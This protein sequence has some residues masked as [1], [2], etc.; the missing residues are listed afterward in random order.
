ML[1][2]ISRDKNAKG[3]RQL[4]IR[5]QLEYVRHTRGTI[6]FVNS[7]AHACEPPVQ[8]HKHQTFAETN[9]WGRSSADFVFYI[10]LCICQIFYSEQGSIYLWLAKNAVYPPATRLSS[11]K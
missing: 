7:K 10:P 6:P 2:G 11:V 9:L 4:S 3:R 8:P 1:S 5:R